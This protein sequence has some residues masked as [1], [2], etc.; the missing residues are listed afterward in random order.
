[1]AAGIGRRNAAF[2]RIRRKCNNDLLRL[3][4]RGQRFRSKAP[5][6]QMEPGLCSG[7][8]EGRGNHRK[9]G[10]A[11]RQAGGSGDR[12][13]GGCALH[14]TGGLQPADERGQ[15]AAPNLPGHGNRSDSGHDDERRARRKADRRRCQPAQSAGAGKAAGKN[16]RFCS[17]MASGKRRRRRGRSPLHGLSPRFGRRFFG[18]V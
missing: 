12:H 10:A 5:A 13:P 6:G 4:D 17:R 3:A 1:M 16:G 9:A 18:C 15:E 14:N 7:C 11:F 8:P 2:R